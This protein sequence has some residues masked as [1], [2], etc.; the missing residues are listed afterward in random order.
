MYTHVTLSKC[1]DSYPC[2]VLLLNILH[3]LINDGG[4]GQKKQKTLRKGL[5]A[6]AKQF[7][8]AQG[9]TVN[10]K[11]HIVERRKV[12]FTLLVSQVSLAASCSAQSEAQSF[13]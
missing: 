1:V 11:N 10:Y 7:N 6:L 12:D 4:L 5:L 13:A 2:L 9:G 3:I 8:S